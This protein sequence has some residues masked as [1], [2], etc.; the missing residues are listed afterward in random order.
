VVAE[1][2]AGGLAS[3]EASESGARWTGRRL[4]RG[5]QGRA[6]GRRRPGGSRRG[7]TGEQRLGRDGRCVRAEAR[8]SESLCVGR[9]ASIGRR[10]HGSGAALVSARVVVARI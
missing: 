7:T 6:G 1:A 8:A 2:E 3:V 5:S 10:A 4:R 9:A